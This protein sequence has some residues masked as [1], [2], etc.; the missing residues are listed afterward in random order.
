MCRPPPKK[1]LYTVEWSHEQPK[2]FQLNNMYNLFWR[3]QRE[4][5][6]SISVFFGSIL[7]AYLWNKKDEVR[8]HVLYVSGCATA[9][10]QRMKKKISL[11]LL[12]E[13]SH[14]FHNCCYIFQ[15]FFNSGYIMVCC[16][17]N[18]SLWVPNREWSPFTFHRFHLLTV[19]LLLF[20]FLNYSVQSAKPQT[21]A[22]AEKELPFT[23]W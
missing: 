4:H 18:S 8:F 10:L 11:S 21:A 2:T 15:K 20:I 13:V 3:K 5:E 9:I 17:I 12:P 6:C 22:I 1:V 23:S 14:F 7:Y 19:V 16:L